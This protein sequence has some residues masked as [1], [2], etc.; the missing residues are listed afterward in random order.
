MAS[1]V[2]VGA[3]NIIAVAAVGVDG[4]ALVV[5]DF[6]FGEEAYVYILLQQ[7]VAGKLESVPAPIGNVIG[8]NVES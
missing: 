1:P 4:V 7:G 8:S 6:Y 3:E 2:C 5:G